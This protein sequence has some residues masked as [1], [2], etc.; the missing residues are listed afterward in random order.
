MNY[1]DCHNMILN[2]SFAFCRLQVKTCD[3]KSRHLDCHIIGQDPK[4]Y[5]SHLYLMV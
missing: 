5:V 3:S 2:S 1:S 4:F